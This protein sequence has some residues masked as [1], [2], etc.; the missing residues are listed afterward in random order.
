M[1][2]APLATHLSVA[3]LFQITRKQQSFLLTQL[4]DNNNINP[5]A[6]TKKVDSDSKQNL[7][8]KTN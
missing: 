6:Y 5:T 1:L 8:P 3:N 4:T 2:E 7:N